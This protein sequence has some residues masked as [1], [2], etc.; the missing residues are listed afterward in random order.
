VVVASRAAG[1]LGSGGCRIRLGAAHRGKRGH[2]HHPGRLVEHHAAGDDDGPANHHPA[3]RH[4]LG[5]SRDHHHGGRRLRGAGHRGGGEG[6]GIF[7]DDAPADAPFP[8]PQDLHIRFTRHCELA[9]ADYGLGWNLG[10]E[11]Y[12]LSDALVG[13]THGV[14]DYYWVAGVPDDYG[15]LVDVKGSFLG[16]W[17]TAAEQLGT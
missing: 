9:W 11:L 12:E 5:A 7:T 17:E 1:A 8:D 3:H 10:P 15:R 16:D 6:V 13:W 14:R 2:D 4:Y